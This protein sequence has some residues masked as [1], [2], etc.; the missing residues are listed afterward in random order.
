MDLDYEKHACQGPLGDQKC[1]SPLSLWLSALNAT[2][3]ILHTAPDFV[4]FSG[5]VP[6]IRV[7]VRSVTWWVYSC[8]VQESVYLVIISLLLDRKF[9]LC[10]KLT[11]S[12]G[13]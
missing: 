12:I 1:D 7:L 4:V 3:Q 9:D 5:S 11:I 13:G 10:L 2:R 6:Y 8:W